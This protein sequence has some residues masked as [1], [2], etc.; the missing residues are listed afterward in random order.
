M[1][2]TGEI[3][4]EGGY[5]SVI[6]HCDAGACIGSFSGEVSVRFSNTHVRIHG[7]GN[8]IAGFGSTDGACDTRIES[9]NVSAEL[10]ARERMLLG[11]EHSRVIIT[12]GNVRI[13]PENG[14]TPFS[15]GNLPLHCETPSEDHF[16][17]SF[18]DRRESWTYTADRDEDGHLY[19]WVPNS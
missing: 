9:G 17:A 19:V 3:Q 4:L 10:L 15:P 11:N 2:G 7:E 16:E 12:G 6:L 8:R 13:F 1:S 5:V 14:Q 18:K